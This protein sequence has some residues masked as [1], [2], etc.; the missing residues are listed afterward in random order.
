MFLAFGA[1]F[2]TPVQLFLRNRH[3]LGVFYAYNDYGVRKGSKSGILLHIRSSGSGYLVR[4]CKFVLIA[5]K[6]DV[7][8]RQVTI[9]LRLGSYADPEDVIC[10]FLAFGAQFRTPEQLFLRNRHIL[11]V[12]YT[13]SDYGVRKGSKSGIL[14][15]IRSTGSG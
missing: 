3:N 11:G 6:V 9:V 2:R 15:H 14:L 1:Q 12:F 7:P 10:M 8:H 13:N 4:M 5:R